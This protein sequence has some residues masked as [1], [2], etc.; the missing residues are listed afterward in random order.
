MEQ[1]ANVVLVDVND[2]EVASFI[3]KRLNVLAAMRRQ[4]LFML[5]NDSKSDENGDDE[6]GIMRGQL[7]SAASLVCSL[8]DKD[9]NLVY[10]QKEYPKLT[11]IDH[12]LETMDFEVYQALAAACMEINPPTSLKAKKKKS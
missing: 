5:I 11:A 10:T 9:G 7:Y 1:T 4:S 12:M 3:V 2:K 6:D 8:C